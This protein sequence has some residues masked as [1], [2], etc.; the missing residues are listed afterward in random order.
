MHTIQVYTEK[1]NSKVKLIR[2]KGSSVLKFPLNSM[3]FQTTFKFTFD[4]FLHL[5]TSI[6]SK[7]YLCKTM[8]THFIWKIKRE[9]D[10][11]EYVTSVWV[12]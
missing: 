5:F 12:C 7:I 6:L 1:S 4:T 11:L 10:R 9:I 2:F 8:V 3:C